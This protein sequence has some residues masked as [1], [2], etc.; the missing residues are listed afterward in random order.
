MHRFCLGIFLAAALTLLAQRV[1]AQDAVPMHLS[2]EFSADE[3]Y[4]GEASVRRSSRIIED[5]DEHDVILRFVFTPRVKLGVLRIG[6][7]F[8]RF[9]FG[10][11]NGT[12]LP[13][14]L[15][16]ASFVCGI[17]TQW[18]DSI[19]IRF[20][21]QPGFYGTNK[22]DFDDINVPFLVGGTYIYSP[23]L[24]LILG[25]SVDIERQFPVIPAAGIRWR[26]ARDW[27]ANL[28]LPEPRIEYEA[29]KNLTL[30]LGGN[31]KQTNFRVPDDFGKT[32]A[33]LAL[34]HAVLSYSEARVGVG[35]DWKLASFVTATVE[36]GYQPYRSFD[37]YRADV[38]YHENGSAPYGMISLHGAF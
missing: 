31:I 13:N 24:Q 34:N 15:Q 21:A 16:Q 35:I 11:P 4:V 36:A 28:V 19:L 12:P 27:I 23:N 33:N 22:V 9:S 37:F 17:D 38:R 30:Y 18:S 26:F 2:G 1:P 3:T 29:T 32:H 5:F 7:E 14:T 10:F 6:G 8:E 20:E 25:V